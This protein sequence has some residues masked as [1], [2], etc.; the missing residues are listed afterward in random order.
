M[1]GFDLKKFK[2]LEGMLLK[3]TQM[4]AISAARVAGHGDDDVHKKM[5][6]AA[7]VNTMREYL[8]NIEGTTTTIKIGEGVR[9]KAPMLYIGEKIGN[10]PFEIDLAVDPVENTNATAKL[11]PNAIS[12][13]AASNPGGLIAATDGYMDKIV[14]G[15]KVA[16]KIN[17]LYPVEDN[18]T[19]IAAALKRDIED[20]TITI[21]DRERNEDLINRVRATGA[22]T[23][24]IKDGDLMP[25]IL[26]CISSS[27]THALMGIGASPEGV[28]TATAVKILGG[29]M[30]VKFWPENEN[31]SRKLISL[32]IDPN[33][34]YNQNDLASGDNLIFCA[35]AITSLSTATRHILE[36]VSFFGGAAK[37]NSLLITNNTVEMISTT[38]ILNKSE[39]RDSKSEFRL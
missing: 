26:T 36:G 8:A 25:G 17:I 27:S 21:L 14:V 1:V 5:V 4:A 20:L 15:P 31:D 9:D 16:G 12:V 11:G 29:E 38:H 35:T 24:L 18:I 33:K 10:G 3:V 23:Q 37:T 7:A 22:R 6:D 19:I 28:I 2:D 34:V 39:F 32:G 13:L 30:Q